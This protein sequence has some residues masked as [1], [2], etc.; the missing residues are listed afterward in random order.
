MPSV[1]ILCAH[2]PHR[3]PSQRYRFEQYLPFLEGNGFTFTWSYLLNEENDKLFYSHGNVFTKARILFK[4]LLIRNK[5]VKRFKDFDI[6]FIQR[7]AS[8]IGSSF[9]EKKARE[10]GAKVI[11]DFDDSI[12]L[13]DTSPGNR[14]WQWIKRPEKFFDNIKYAS[15]VIAGNEYLASK[16]RLVN[17][18]TFVI[19]TTIDTDHHVP[20]PQL[21]NKDVVTIGWSGSLTT[22]K[23]FELL[24]PVLTR[25]NEKY[26]GKVHFKIIGEKNYFNPLLTIEA[27]AWSEE[28]EVDQLNSLDIGIMPLENDEWAMGKCGLKGLSY[29]ACEVT[30]VMSNVGVN[31]EIIEDGVNGFLAS[32]SDEW[33]EILSH[34]IENKE[35]R[36]KLG[37]AGRQT[38]IEKYSFLANKNKYLEVFT[39]M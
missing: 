34:L 15:A 10:S 36:L 17:S 32:N 6:V 31:R 14:K 29:M 30:A 35:L 37:K 23:H 13:A 19:P 28:T 5:D 8:F 20:K 3:S 11:F 38:V 33:F 18:N 21:R 25:I 1:L 9:Y 22:I 24:L 7:E 39:N 12:W 27:I 4:T 16:A 26:Q 2:R